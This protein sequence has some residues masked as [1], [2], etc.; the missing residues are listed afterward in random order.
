MPVQCVTS[1]MFQNDGVKFYFELYIFCVMQMRVLCNFQ[2]HISVTTILV[3]YFRSFST[4]WYFLVTIINIFCIR[5]SRFLV[6][7]FFCV[8][9]VSSKFSF[10]VLKWKQWSIKIQKCQDIFKFLNEHWKFG[11]SIEFFIILLHIRRFVTC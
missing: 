3:T 11:F 6:S 2:Y 8:G 9:K 5:Y 7:T 4:L 10:R 1:S